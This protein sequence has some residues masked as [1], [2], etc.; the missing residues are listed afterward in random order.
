MERKVLQENKCEVGCIVIV[1]TN[2]GEDRHHT[3]ERNINAT[4]MFLIAPCDHLLMQIRKSKDS[5]EIG[6]HWGIDGGHERTLST[7]C[8]YSVEQSSPPYLFLRLENQSS[9]PCA[10]QVW[11]HEPSQCHGWEDFAISPGHCLLQGT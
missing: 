8:L 9:V 3:Q 1:M 10:T 11:N 6:F 2:N 7:V 5:R 4:S